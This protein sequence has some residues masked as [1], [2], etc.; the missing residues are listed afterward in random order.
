MSNENILKIPLETGGKDGV[1]RKVKN[2]GEVVLWGSGSDSINFDVHMKMSREAMIGFATHAKR[3]AVDYIKDQKYHLHTDPLGNLSGNQPMGFFLTN[4]SPSLILSFNDMFQDY[5]VLN[6]NQLNNTKRLV[7]NES[8]FRDYP[9]QKAPSDNSLE[10]FEIGFRNIAEVEIFNE[11]GE[12]IT[13]NGY[14]VIL[15]LS[16]QALLGLSSEFIKLSHNFVSGKRYEI[17]YLKH[18]NEQYELGF[19][20]L[21]TSC[22]LTIVCEELQ[23]VYFYEPRFGKL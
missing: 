15:K 18:N 10:A 3:M 8:S 16:E 2:L 13:Q 19:H 22:R 23:N 17:S 6:E 14:D 1:N 7:I 4:R 11:A 12:N 9:I 20:L 21:P 5:F